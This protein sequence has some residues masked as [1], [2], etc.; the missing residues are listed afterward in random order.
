MQLDLFATSEPAPPPHPLDSLEREVRER[1]EGW[2]LAWDNEWVIVKAFAAYMRQQ[3]DRDPEGLI[4]DLVK[5]KLAERDGDK[6]KMTW[7]PRKWKR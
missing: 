6:V 5:A 2:Y 3:G 1:L 7:E 4:G